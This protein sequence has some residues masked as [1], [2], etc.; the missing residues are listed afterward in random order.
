MIRLCFYRGSETFFGRMIRWRLNGP[1]SHVELEFSD[2]ISWSAK[3]GEG[4]RY[5]CIAYQAQPSG[6]DFCSVD[7]TAA[8]ESAVRTW[9]G[10]QVG[11]K[12]DWLG[13]LRF[14]VP[15]LHDDADDYFCSEACCLALQQAGLL[16][17]VRANDVGPD[18][19]FL[20]LAARRG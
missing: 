2:G 5:T 18:E 3:A 12:Y 4:V 7:L 19:L 11:R 6:W 9:C 16:Q 8:Q 10:H 13:I 20:V 14:A 15:W 17:G 1:Y